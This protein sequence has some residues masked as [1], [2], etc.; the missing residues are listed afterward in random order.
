MQTI[1]IVRILS[2][3]L[4]FAWGGVIPEG[5]AAGDVSVNAELSQSEIPSGEMAELQLKVTGSDVADVP[6]EIPAEGLQIRL[7]GQST[8]VQMINFK[9][10]SSAVYSYIVMP[11]RTGH[12]TIPSIPVRTNA[13][14]KQ[15]APLA[16]SVLDAGAT[17]GGASGLSGGGTPGVSPA[18]QLPQPGMPGFQPPRSSTRRVQGVDESKLAFAEI[19]TPKKSLYVGEMIPVEIRYYFDARY[20]VEVS[21]RVDFGSE[22]VLVERFPDPKQGREDRDGMT[23]NVMTFHTLLSA[24]KPGPI[25]ISPAKLQCQI[26]LPGNV[27]PGFDDPV[28]QRLMGG[29]NPFSQPRDLTVKS[30]PL[31]L[32]V[33]PL[34]K[35]GKPASFAGAVGQFDIDSIVAN[36]NPPPG[37]PVTLTIKVG[38]KG[39]FRSMGAP[40]LTDTGGWR[41][42]PPSDKFDSSDE[43]S[44]T[45]VKSFDF[46]LIAQE[47]KKVSPG[48]EFSYFDPITAKYVTL[49]TKPLSL[50][51]SPSAPA[52]L[53]ATTATLQSATPQPELSPR[54]G[55]SPKPEESEMQTGISLHSWRTPIKRTEFLVA[56]LSLLVTSLA[57]AGILYFRKL[58]IQSGG[59]SARR[60]R[61]AELLTNLDSDSLDAAASYD[62]ALEYLKLLADPNAGEM[63]DELSARRDLLKYG[64]GGSTALGREERLKLLEALRQFS[65]RKS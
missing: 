52:S 22:G 40:V 23:Y 8:Q 19:T 37:D 45:G 65:T 9:V 18:S 55:V 25:E 36:P 56:T 3:M 2:L 53:P 32:D 49:S 34:P 17:A 63:I 50:N 15:T 44:Y 64:V 39:S 48:C 41:T 57:L 21:G 1:P 31:H 13:G 24:V 42:Y 62:A 33:M 35:E 27:P 59:A 10:T 26:H 20:P 47:P 60:R 43:L 30:A 5:R 61:L 11:L 16:F 14:L 46:T 6:R 29:Q 51:A 12:F 58:Q 7:T 4:L 28:F 54:S 38:G